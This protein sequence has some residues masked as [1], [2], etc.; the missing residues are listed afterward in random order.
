MCGGSVPAPL[1]VSL[2]HSKCAKCGRALYTLEGA[3]QAVFRDGT[4]RYYDDLGCMATDTEAIRGASQLYVQ[5]AGARGWA[6]VEDVAFAKPPDK[7]TAHGYGYLPYPEDEARRVAPD[8]WARGWSDL[9]AE[10][11]KKPAK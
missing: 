6:R 10:L 11:G 5:M 7:E 1:A 8:R 4:V 3:A 9:V 2:G